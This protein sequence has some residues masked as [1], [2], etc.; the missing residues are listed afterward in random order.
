MKFFKG[1]RDEFANLKEDTSWD[2]KAEL[3][4]RQMAEVLG[5]KNVSFLIGSG[6]SSLR[7]EDVLGDIEELGISTMK[8]LAKDFQAQLASDV[9]PDDADVFVTKAQQTELIEKLGIDLKAEGIS[10]NLEQ[11][12]AVLLNAG[13]FCRS[14]AKAEMTDAAVLVE[15]VVAGLK[16]FVLSRC[17]NGPFAAGDETVVNLYRRF[18]QSLAT[19]SRGLAPPWIFTTNYDLFNERAMDRSGIPYSNGFS[20]TVE[21]RF[22]PATYRLALAEQLDITSRRWATVDGFVHLCKL[23]GSLNWLEEGSGLFPIRESHAPLDPATDRVMIYP[24]PSKQSASFGSP[25]SDMFREF[26]RQV[27]QDQSVLTVMGYSFS[28]EHVNNIIFQ[29]LTLPSFRLVCFLDPETNDVT[30]ELAGLGD[31][32]IWFIWGEGKVEQSPAH[33][34]DSIANHLMPNSSDQ[35]VDQSIEA[36]LQALFA[37]QKG[38]Q[39]GSE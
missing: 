3:I 25:Y 2:E 35:K 36:A 32:R 12:M 24:T 6:C 19:R 17:T 8:F 16:K 34:F 18:Y 13:Q 14:S 7:R 30:R 37:S 22:N 38:G 29:G 31:P 39:D 10:G 15:S 4:Q 28:D 20:G 11:M 1:S 26:Q 9:V 21:R 27:V 23:H 5:A 33:F